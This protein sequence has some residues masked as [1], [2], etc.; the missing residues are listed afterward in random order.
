MMRHCYFIFY[1]WHCESIWVAP[2]KR[3]YFALHAKVSV[4]LSTKRLFCNQSVRKKGK[5]R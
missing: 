1:A 5:G 4:E 2:K 3:T